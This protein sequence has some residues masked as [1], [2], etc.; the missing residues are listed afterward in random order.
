MS[1]AAALLTDETARIAPSHQ[2]LPALL[3]STVVE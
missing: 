2:G 1:L 3:L